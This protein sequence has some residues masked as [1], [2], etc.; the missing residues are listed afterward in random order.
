MP[1]SFRYCL[2]SSAFRPRFR[3]SDRCRSGRGRNQGQAEGQVRRVA[4]AQCVEAREM[5]AATDDCLIQ[6]QLEVEQSSLQVVETG[7]EP[8][9][10]NFPGRASPVI[11]H[12]I[13]ALIDFVVIGHHRPA[14]AQATEDLCGV[15]AYRGGNAKRPALRPLN[16]EPSAWAASSM[17][18]RQC[19]PAIACSG[20]M[21][22]VRPFNWVGMM[23]RV[24]GVIAASTAVGSIR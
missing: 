8:P 15:E 23:A 19:L 6:L 16:F 11:A 12:L 2:R 17:M 21:S 13:D 5:A 10:D 7:I 14:I 9:G 22:Q 20:S 18:R 1:W 3:S 24:R 4:E